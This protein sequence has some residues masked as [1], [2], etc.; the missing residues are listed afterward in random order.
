MTTAVTKVMQFRDLLNACGDDL[1]GL[2]VEAKVKGNQFGIEYLCRLL[3]TFDHAQPQRNNQATL[4]SDQ[5][6]AHFL[7]AFFEYLKVK[8]EVF[9]VKNENDDEVPRCCLSNQDKR[10]AKL[11]FKDLQ[12]A[13]QNLLLSIGEQTLKHS[14]DTKVKHTFFSVFMFCMQKIRSGFIVPKYFQIIRS[15]LKDVMH[16]DEKDE[17]KE[18]MRDFMP[19]V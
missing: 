1:F 6:T 9:D 3:M 8:T 5:Y 2:C 19:I 11:P 13:M 12:E 16:A 18:V 10:L 14:N 4:T 7:D 17:K 15:L